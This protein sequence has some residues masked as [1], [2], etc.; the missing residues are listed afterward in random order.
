MQLEA[1]LLGSK[2]CDRG[3]S[4]NGTENW[5]KLNSITDYLKTQFH[6]ACALRGLKMNQVVVE[7]AF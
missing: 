4:I 5:V 1:A 3:V 7:M 2:H 6:A